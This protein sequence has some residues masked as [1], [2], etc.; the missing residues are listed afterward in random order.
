MQLARKIVA[1]A[2]LSCSLLGGPSHAYFSG[3]KNSLDIAVIEQAKDVYFDSIVKLINNLALPDIYLPDDKGYML[4]NRFVLIESASDVQFTTKPTENAVIFE[5]TD[6]RGTFYCDHFRYKETI[7]VAKGSV[8]VDLKKIQITA[9]VGFGKQTLADGRMVPL[10]EAVDVDMD[11]DRRDI[12]IHLHG[13]IWTDFA[14]LFEI[15][16]KGTVIGMIEDTAEAAMNTGIPL[17]G[18][19][20]MTKLDGYFPIPIVPKWVVDWETPQPA[21]VTDTRF[22]IGVKGLMFD[23]DIGE[24]DP[25][26]TAPDMPYYDSSRA[27]Q[28]QAFVS[29]YSIDGFFNSL[30]EVEGGLHGWYNS[31]MVPSFVPFSLTT[32]TVNTLLPGIVKTYG[33]DLPVDVHFNVTSLGDF[34]VSEAN[35]EMSGLTSLTLQFWV[36]LADGT[37]ALAAEL[38]L[39][40]VDFKFTALV[41]NMD[42]AL[43]IT[44]V[45]VDSVDVI[46]STVGRLSAL[47]IKVE[48]NNGF[49]IGL[50]FFNK[51]MAKHQIPIPSNIGGLFVL[52]NLTLGYHDN[53]IYAGATPT[54][55]GPSSSDKDFFVQ[56]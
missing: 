49:R 32:D 56:E 38:G 20:V 3:V 4:D 26:V 11:I 24:E 27:E 51:V 21:V 34:A 42:V 52:S 17:I 22:A 29:S 44:K 7:F 53:Y 9:G 54:F 19:T 16:F 5:V 48:L 28:Y 39:N 14:S 12:D 31:T 45:N 37:Q 25:G 43:N 40:S 15:F 33:S 35:E 1:A 41:E 6:F 47:T 2:A 46:S 36:E 50:P 55:I 23:R 18:N 13:N 30:I 10:I 8:E